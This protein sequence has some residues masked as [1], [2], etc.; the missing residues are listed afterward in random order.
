MAEE[1]T[2]S[3]ESYDPA[4]HYRTENFSCGVEALDTFLTSQMS[5]QQE[6]RILRC[7]VLVT[8]EAVPE[9]MGFYT[10]SGASYEKQHLSGSR[11]R[12]LPYRN[13]PC[14]L[15]GRLA[16]DRRLQRRG[17]GEKFLFD[18]I[19]RT[20]LTAG[21]VGIYALF[22][23]AKDEA[24]VK[25]YQSLGFTLSKSQPLTLFYPVNQFEFLI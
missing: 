5:V 2:L 25:F 15:L 17:F 3:I 16:V 23:E 6:R 10:L 18:A 8:N 4:R 21:M 9:I 20:W 22:V 11:Q 12:K 14:V 13:L 19:R 1:L 7:Y 24:A